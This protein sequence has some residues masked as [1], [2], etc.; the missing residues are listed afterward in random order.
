MANKGPSDYVIVESHRDH[1]ELVRRRARGEERP[2]RDGMLPRLAEVQPQLPLADWDTLLAAQ[3]ILFRI[4]S[5]PL[6]VDDVLAIQDAIVQLR[7]VDRLE[8]LVG[9]EDLHRDA[10]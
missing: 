10:L 8:R 1:T 6:D 2:L 7:L 3:S 9:T 5:G 4:A